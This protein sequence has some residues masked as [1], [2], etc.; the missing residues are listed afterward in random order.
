LNGTG[1]TCVDLDT[2]LCDVCYSHET[3]DFSSRKRRHEDLI[4]ELK[5][6]VKRQRKYDSHAR[7]KEQEVAFRIE[8]W[9]RIEAVKK[10]IG[11]GCPVCWFLMEVDFNSHSLAGCCVWRGCF[12]GLTMGGI[13]MK[14]L[15]YKGLKTVCWTCGLPGD[16]C[17]EYADATRRCSGQDI[18]IPVVLYFWQQADSPYHELV[19]RALGRSFKDLELLGLELVRRARVLEENGSVA[20]KIWL[21]VFKHRVA[22]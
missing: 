19:G 6:Q 14:F 17:P 10:E 21:E 1:S 13:R 18:V 15:D 11:G 12:G 22:N 3:G 7:M 4:E 2:P 5:N 9:E 20:F 8:M 16:R